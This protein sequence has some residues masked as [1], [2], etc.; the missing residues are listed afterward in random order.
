VAAG[1]EAVLEARL[2]RSVDTKGWISS[3]F[4]SHSSPSGD[5]TSSQRGRVLNLLCEHIEFAPC[6]EHN[7]IDTYVPHLKALNVESIFATCTGMELT[8]GPLPVNHQNAF[9]LDRKPHTQD[10]GAPVTDVDPV[11][12]V[13]R[14]AMWDNTS[15]KLVQMNHPNLPQILGDKNLDG[16]PDGGFEEMFGWI[17]VMEIHPPG[18]IFTVPD[19]K[20]DPKKRYAIFHWMQMLNLGYRVPGTVNTDA[21]YN[22]HG[23]GWLRNFIKCSTDD[24][25]KIDEMEIVHESTRGHVVVSNGPFLE[26]SLQGKGEK[27]KPAIPGDEIKVPGGRCS[28]SVRVQCPNWFDIN[29]VQVF[30]NG[31]PEPSLNF[32]RRTT[33]DRFGNEVVKF[34][35]TIPLEL[36]RDTHV[37]VATTGEGLSLGEVMGADRGK[38][39][40]AAVANPVFV[41][42]D[43]NGFQPNGDLLGVP[44]PIQDGHSPTMRKHSHAHGHDHHHEHDHEH[45]H[46]PAKRK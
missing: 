35:A 38:T 28:L 18:D 11:V 41:D 13:S 20:K 45:D 10:N 14:L 23:S 43:G 46:A 32:T 29:R 36:K 37:I 1:K 21:H 34:E 2:V 6:T 44:L 15:D 30:L 5:N 39:A 16:K 4:H 7:R 25:A 12:Q 9:P 17:D 31:R 40:P 24:P 33:P 19:A 27:E 26:V 22:H 3:D 42:V 8:G